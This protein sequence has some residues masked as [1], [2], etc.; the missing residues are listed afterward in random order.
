MSLLPWLTA[1]KPFVGVTDLKYD[2]SIV[3]RAER[4]TQLKN[5]IWMKQRPFVGSVGL[6]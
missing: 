6:V 4:A 2:F 3:W 1:G 5:H